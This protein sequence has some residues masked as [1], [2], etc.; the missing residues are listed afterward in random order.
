MMELPTA[1]PDPDVLLAL[2]PEELADISAQVPAFVHSAGERAQTR[3][4][5]SSSITSATHAC[6][7][8]MA[9]RLANSPPGA[10]SVPSSTSGRR[11][12]GFTR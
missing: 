6:G 5:K 9:A 10:S 1:I 7:A 12:G 3:F 8:P 11:I 4:L 2:E